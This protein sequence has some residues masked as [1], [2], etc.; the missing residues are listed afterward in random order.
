M[1][2]DEPVNSP[3]AHP[4]S[5]IHLM[6]WTLDNFFA[7]LRHPSTLPDDILVAPR[8]PHEAAFASPDDAALCPCARN[9]FIA[10]FATAECALV[11]ILLPLLSADSQAASLATARAALQ[12]IARTEIS[13]FCAI[14]QQRHDDGRCTAGH[15]AA[16]SSR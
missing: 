6:D 5:L 2:R 11:E 15:A 7:E 10:Y 4:D 12:R 14:C 8:N 3:L 9:P 1:L 16:G 13:T